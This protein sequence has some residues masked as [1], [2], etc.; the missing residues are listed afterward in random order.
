MAQAFGRCAQGRQEFSPSHEGKGARTSL[1]P[2]EI[3]LSQSRQNL[4]AIKE[5]SDEV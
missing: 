4:K 5:L 3:T 2:V 1:L